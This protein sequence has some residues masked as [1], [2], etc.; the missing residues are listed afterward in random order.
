MNER[1]FFF[2]FKCKYHTSTDTNPY[3]MSERNHIFILVYSLQ[4]GNDGIVYEFDELKRAWFPLITP[5]LIQAQQ[6]AYKVDGVD[7]NVYFNNYRL[8]LKN[9]D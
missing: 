6:S 8:L 7:E 1:E 9:Q 3:M 4:Q 2:V 5:D